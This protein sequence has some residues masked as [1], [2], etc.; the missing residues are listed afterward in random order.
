MSSFQSQKRISR[1][2]FKKKEVQIFLG[3]ELKQIFLFVNFLRKITWNE[4]MKKDEFIS[5]QQT[6]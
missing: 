1:K 6:G 3:A 5:F 4:K 2:S